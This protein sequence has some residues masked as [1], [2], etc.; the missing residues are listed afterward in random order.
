[1]ELIL[2]RHGETAQNH[3]KQIQGW[4]DNPLNDVGRTQAQKAA[5]YLKEINYIPEVAYTSPLVRASE[6]GEIILG[7]I[8]PKISLNHDFHF[9]ERN[10][11]SYEETLA[12]PTL[13]KV[14]APGFSEAGFESDLMIQKRVL[15]GL[16]NIYKLH[17]G[18]KVIIF[19]HSHT[20]KSC[21][22]LADKDKYDYK[23]FIDNGSMHKLNFDG[24]TLQILEFSFNI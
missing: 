1:M 24:K 9:I 15:L 3:L 7:F 14:L 8:N 2:V 19:C 6:T 20:I 5:K 23:L 17:Q 10:F 18:K 13:K 11:G 22:I 4:A 12:I 16:K 21:L